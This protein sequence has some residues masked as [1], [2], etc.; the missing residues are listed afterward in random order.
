M[1]RRQN[2][3]AFGPL[4]TVR[5]SLMM[6]AETPA[7]LADPNSETE[8]EKIEEA[9]WEEDENR[10]TGVLRAIF[11]VFTLGLLAWAQWQTPIGPSQNWSR[12]IQTSLVFNFL[13]PLFIVWMFFGQG[14]RHLDWLKDQRHNAWN[15]GWNW[16]N[17]RAHL[18]F[19]ALILLISLPFLIYFSRQD[20]IRASYVNYYPPV[21]SA[22]SWA[23]FLAS[24]VLYMFCWEWFFRA[25]GLFG[26][27][28]GFGPIAAILIQAAAFGLAHYGKPPVEMWSSFAGGALLGIWCWREKSWVPAFFTHTLIQCVWAVLVKI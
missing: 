19:S 9:S 7:P 2:F 27:A 21:D 3:N 22:Q 17:W 10:A 12:W 16:K 1:G 14:L 5:F 24:L 18:K 26:T 28:Q 15:Y 20:A 11:T 25:F 4:L 23:F 13:V 8:T 6:S